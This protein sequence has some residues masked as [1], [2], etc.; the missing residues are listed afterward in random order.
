M[1]NGEAAVRN[2]RQRLERLEAT[3]AENP[4]LIRVVWDDDADQEAAAGARIRLRW[5]DDHE[6][7]RE[8]PAAP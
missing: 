8:A 6:P 3:E 2:L 4:Y 7:P 1:R 5:G